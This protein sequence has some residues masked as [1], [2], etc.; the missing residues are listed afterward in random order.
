MVVMKNGV[1]RDYYPLEDAAKV[2]LC[3]A[4]DLVHFAA[5]GECELYAL[6]SREFYLVPIVLKEGG[7][8]PL[9]DYWSSVLQYSDISELALSCT[10]EP[11]A[12]LADA[13]RQKEAGQMTILPVLKRPFNL[14]V[15]L[16]DYFDRLGELLQGDK[17]FLSE[18]WWQATDKNGLPV[19]LDELKIVLIRE[20]ME[21]LQG[22]SVE[23]IYSVGAEVSGDHEGAT[24][25]V[26][27]NPAEAIT[28][29]LR[30]ATTA[31]I[32]AAF[33]RPTQ[34]TQDWKR[35]LGGVQRDAPWLAAARVEKGSRSIPALWSPSLFAFC[36]VNQRYLSK[37]RAQKII[38][39]YFESWISDWEQK[40][41]QL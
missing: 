27:T 13:W 24:E 4:N 5:I 39:E 6:P 12:I 18:L 15:V 25:C 35:F 29:P 16:E 28:L 20:E 23:E 36:M 17:W 3:T 22:R 9:F 1:R 40:S 31:E 34:I 38:R 8:D 7:R 30:L 21:R 2:L 10:D 14:K 19:K 26:S 37:A 11:I 33:E 41:E 32:A